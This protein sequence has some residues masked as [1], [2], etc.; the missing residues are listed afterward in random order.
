MK[1]YRIIF[2]YGG[3][4]HHEIFVTED[5]LDITMQTLVKA[6]VMLKLGPSYEVKSAVIEVNP[7]PEAL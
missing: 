3:A 5:K 4:E 6:A 7:L 2:G 1:L